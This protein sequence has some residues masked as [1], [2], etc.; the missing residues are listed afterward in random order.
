MPNMLMMIAQRYEAS[1]GYA[2]LIPRLFHTC[3]GRR[4]NV[5]LGVDVQRNSPS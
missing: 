2:Q 4:Q 5:P 3:P 1:D